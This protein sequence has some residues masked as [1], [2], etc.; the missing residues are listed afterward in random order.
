LTHFENWRY[1]RGGEKE[2]KRRR[3]GERVKEGKIKEG[4]TDK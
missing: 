2:R 3:Q 4:K 1:E